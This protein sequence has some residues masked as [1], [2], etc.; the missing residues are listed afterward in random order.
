MLQLISRCLTV[1]SDLLE[2]EPNQAC[3]RNVVTLA[4]V[5]PALAFGDTCKLLLFAV[6]LLN[7]PAQA[8]LFM[9]SLSGILTGPPGGQVVGYQPFCAVGGDLYPEQPHL[10]VKGE[11]M[12]FDQFAFLPLGAR[13]V[14]L[15]DGPVGQFGVAVVNFPVGLEGAVEDLVLADNQLHNF[16]RG[17]P[18]I[19]QNVAEQ[20]P[21]VQGAQQHISHVVEFGSCHRAQGRRCGS[22]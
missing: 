16:C 14:Q 1:V 3:C 5:S 8:A 19:H 7:L 2:P 9:G 21:P 4:S 13:P 17:I 10:D 15:A 11:L 18:T 20:H 6:K 22:R 12:Q